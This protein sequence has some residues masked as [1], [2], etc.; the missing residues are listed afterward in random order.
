MNSKLRFTHELISKDTRFYSKKERKVM[1]RILKEFEDIDKM[2][3]IYFNTENPLIKVDGTI[4]LYGYK[5]EGR[6]F[7][8]IINFAYY[9]EE[10]SVFKNAEIIETKQPELQF[11]KVKI[12]LDKKI[13]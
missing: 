5:V 1:Q 10:S 13:K 2:Q 6:G 9:S 3:I 11:S 7:L 12:N 8:D 4:H